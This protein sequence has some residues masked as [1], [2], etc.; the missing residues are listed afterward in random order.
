MEK[1]GQAIELYLGS[2]TIK[3][4]AQSGAGTTGKTDAAPYV[5]N[6]RTFV[7]LRFFAEEA[8][9]DVQWVKSYQTAILRYK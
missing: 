8:G 7:P 4:K 3:R 5:K 1:G 2:T 6:H 9:M